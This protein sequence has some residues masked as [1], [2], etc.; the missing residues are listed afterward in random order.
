[1][2]FLDS[3]GG[4]SMAVAAGG[5]HCYPT[6]ALDARYQVDMWPKLVKVD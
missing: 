3:T 6:H 4:A 2:R 5:V 1:M